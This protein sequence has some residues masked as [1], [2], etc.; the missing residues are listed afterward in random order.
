MFGEDFTVLLAHQDF[1]NASTTFPFL[2]V[3]LATCQVTCPKAACKD[4]FAKLILRSDWEKL[5]GKKVQAD[6]LTAEQL[7]AAAWEAGVKST[8]PLEKWALAFGQFQIRL[9]LHLLG[10]EMKGR[11][12]K[13]YESFEA[14]KS[15]FEH[16]MLQC[17]QGH[18]LE[19]AGSEQEQE[20][21]AV[22]PLAEATDAK[23]IALKAHRHIKENKFYTYKE[24]KKVYKL[25]EVTSTVAKLVHTPFFQAQEDMEVTHNDLKHLKEWSKAVPELIADEVKQSL[26]PSASEILNEELVRGEAQSALLR[27]YKEHLNCALLIESCC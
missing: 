23:A 5:K 24:S 14:I 22:K 18:V 6:V 26:L 4:G 12:E 16:A 8:V 17:N 15:K 2:R 27:K 13:K 1:K 10:K 25:V 21:E 3:G 20:K 11:E 9:C 19:Q 7:M